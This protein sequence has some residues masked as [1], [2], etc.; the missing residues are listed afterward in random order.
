MVGTTAAGLREFASLHEAA[1]MGYC[2]GCGEGRGS[3]TGLLFVGGRG[4]DAGSLGLSPGTP[5]LVVAADSGLSLAL[6]LGFTPDLVVGDMDSLP[7]R[8]LLAGFPADR[9]L[10][11]PRDKDETDTEI[12][13]RILHERGCGEVTI[14]GGGGGR[15]DHIFAIAALFERPRPPRR[16]VTEF[17]DVRL[18]EGEAVLEGWEGSTVSFFPLG[19]GAAAL[20]SQGLAWSLDGLAFRRGE[21][22]ISNRVVSPRARVAVGEG[23][24][25]MVRVLREQSR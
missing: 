2:R 17:E 18:V 10:E 21:A 4:P 25:L 15:L 3:M 13:L 20:A 22:S 7:D 16:W 12:G 8:R 1:Q 9:V 14:A 23:R 5:S 6:E 19:A 11:F 24:L